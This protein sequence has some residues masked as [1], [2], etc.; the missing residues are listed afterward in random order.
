PY[1][2]EPFMQPFR[3]H[4]N[5]MTFI[6]MAQKKVRA[7]Q[8]PIASPPVLPLPLVLPSSPLSHPQDS[9][10]QKIMP[11]RKRAH[12]LSQPSSSTD[13]SIS[14]R[15]NAILNHLDEFPFECFEQTVLFDSGADKSFVSIS[16]ASMLNIPP[17]AL[18]T[19]DDIK[20][21]DGNL[22]GTNTVIQGCT[23]ILLNQR[24]KIDLMPIKISSFDIVI[25]MEWL[26][27]YHAKIICD[28]KVV[29]IPIDDETLI[30]RGD[31]SKT[32][33]SLISCIKTKRYISRGCQVFIDHVMEKNSTE[34]RLGDI[35]VVR[36]FSKVFPKDLPSLP[37][38]HQVEFQ[39]DITP[40]AVRMARAPY[41]LA[42][43]EM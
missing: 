39:I 22:V 32:R 42:R 29:H 11:P 5:G 6:H 20:M 2:P 24:F 36:E 14:P 23:L 25:G 18:D 35:P 38:V 19:I 40:G 3:Y 21:A 30:I 27:K 26:S 15:V 28:E 16:L 43:S 33:L 34:R 7:P 17:I 41:R 31:Q 9:V 37:L 1:E 4:P 12:F 10:L 13:L 8:A